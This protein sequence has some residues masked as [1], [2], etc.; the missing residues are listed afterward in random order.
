MSKDIDPSILRHFSSLSDPR[1]DNGRHKLIDIIE[2]A[3]CGVIAN[4]DRFEYIAEF[5]RA[6]YEWLGRLLKTR[7]RQSGKARG[8]A[9]SAA[10]SRIC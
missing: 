10:Y 3:I 2:I 8:D 6:K 5:G 1:G 7:I 9:T 4:A